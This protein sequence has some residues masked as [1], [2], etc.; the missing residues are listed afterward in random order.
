MAPKSKQYK[1]STAKIFPIAINANVDTDV[2][3]KEE[4]DNMP[5]VN[6]FFILLK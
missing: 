1:R 6:I 3:I 2:A 5:I 4:I